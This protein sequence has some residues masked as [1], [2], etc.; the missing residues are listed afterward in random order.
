MDQHLGAGDLRLDFVAHLVGD[1]VGTLERW[2]GRHTDPGAEVDW[3]LATNRGAGRTVSVN[4]SCVPFVLRST[5]RPSAWRRLLARHESMMTRQQNHVNIITPTID[6]S[7]RF[8]EHIS[9]LERSCFVGY[10]VEQV[11]VLETTTRT[12]T[13]GVWR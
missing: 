9:G 1:R 3:K 12:E 8:G 11:V 10:Y 7:V 4:I 13:K 6:A 5:P 2:C